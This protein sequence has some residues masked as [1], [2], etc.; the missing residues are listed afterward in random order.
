[1]NYCSNC[2]SHVR[3]KVP[4]G[5]ELPRY[6]CESCGMVHY[7]NPKMVV[8]CIPEYKDGIL[9]CRRSIEPRLGYWT[10][11]AGYLENSENVT[12]AAIRETYEETGS[13][14]SILELYSVITLLNVHQVY[15]IFRARLLD[16]DFGPTEES[17]E[18]RLFRVDEIPWKEIAF[19]SVYKTLKF[20]VKE[21]A[22]S[23]FTMH[24]GTI[25]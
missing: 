3:L 22:D 9:L 20:Y 8:G 19:S 2:G 11:P 1:M 24:F 7:D 16:K 23:N 5:D 12:D 18:V 13:R 4:P 21:K 6:I 14:V 25:P 15:L 17:S 10:I